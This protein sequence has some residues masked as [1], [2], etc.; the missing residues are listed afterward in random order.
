MS[1]DLP[2]GLPLTQ[3]APDAS[4]LG[5]LLRHN[6]QP[7]WDLG[8][9]MAEKLQAPEATTILALRYAEGVVMVGD[10]RATEGHTIAHRRMQKVYPADGFS[11]VAIAGT[12]GLAMEMVKLFQTE[13]EHYE[14]LEGTR[15]SLEGKANHLARMVRQQ[16]PMV[17]QGLVVVPLFCGY[18]EEESAGR[19]YTYDVVG[20]RYEEDDY[21]A[22]GSGG[23]EAKAYL[24]SVYRDD[25]GEEE[26]LTQ[27][28]AAIAA[29][30]EQDTATGGPDIR[31]HIYSTAVLVNRDGYREVDEGRVAELSQSL[32]GDS[33]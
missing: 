7:S 2:S 5:L 14:K 29:A 26:A 33:E 17:F 6:L 27:G 3:H 12:A 24:R 23:R 4:F 1:L 11:A 19:L 9:G 30:A 31:R 18:D 21:A 20:G 28:I 16:L 10:R 22:S 13:L 32:V 25:L 8:P 15:L